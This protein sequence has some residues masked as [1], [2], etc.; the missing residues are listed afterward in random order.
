MNAY[1]RGP[2]EQALVRA[3]QNVFIACLSYSVVRISHPCRYAVKKDK[4]G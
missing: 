1:H 4:L 3:L 2:F